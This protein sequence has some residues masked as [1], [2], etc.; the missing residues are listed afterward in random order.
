M[1]LKGSGTIGTPKALGVPG[2]LGG[3]RGR[4]C[5]RVSSDGLRLAFSLLGGGGYLAAPSSWVD[6]AFGVAP[7]PPTTFCHL[8]MALSSKWKHKCA[9]TQ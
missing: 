5:R 9:S 1:P 4:L 7:P 8:A 6:G 3:P 2:V